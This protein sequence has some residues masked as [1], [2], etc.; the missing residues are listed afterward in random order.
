LLDGG[1]S[2][3]LPSPH[4]LGLRFSSLDG[5]SSLALAFRWS[6]SSALR[7][8][9][10]DGGSSLVLGLSGLVV[11]WQVASSKR[12][13]TGWSSGVSRRLRVD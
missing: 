4:L 5:G 8:S 6:R 12:W 13:G 3:A 2:L 9:S 1:S 11:R 7:F 10:L